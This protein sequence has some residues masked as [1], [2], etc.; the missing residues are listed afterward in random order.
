MHFFHWMRVKGLSSVLVEKYFS[1]K[2][3]Y[4]AR[5]RLKTQ[6]PSETFKAYKTTVKSHLMGLESIRAQTAP[7]WSVWVNTM[8]TIENSMNLIK[9]SL[10]IAPF[11]LGQGGGVSKDLRVLVLQVSMERRS[12]VIDVTFLVL[13]QIPHTLL[14]MK[15]MVDDDVNI[16]IQGC[17]FSL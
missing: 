12:V 16:F 7:Q 5:G 17:A 14:S 11:S 13:Y 1:I 9:A 4:A 10:Q 8:L 3:P 2:W 6:C 15:G